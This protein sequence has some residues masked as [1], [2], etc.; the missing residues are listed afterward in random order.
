M[1]ANQQPTTV[2]IFFCRQLD[3]DQDLNRRPLERELGR[4]I[5][6]FPL[7]C[8][9]RIEALHLLKALESGA[10]KVYLVTCPE[11]AC[12][13]GQGNI[14]AGKRLEYARRLIQEI[15]IPGDRLELVR[16]SEPLPLSI[17]TLARQLLGMTAGIADGR[18]AR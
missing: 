12:K 4:D 2:A 1:E 7:P 11:G 17:D 18:T 3:P 6:F 10:G 15:D 16:A 5:R 8:G 14:R 9:G 13:Y